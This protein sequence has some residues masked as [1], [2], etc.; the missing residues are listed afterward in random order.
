MKYKIWFQPIPG[1]SIVQD[2]TSVFYLNLT[3]DQRSG[4]LKAFH[5]LTFDDPMSGS[6]LAILTVPISG[7]EPEIDLYTLTNTPFLIQ[8][9]FRIAELQPFL[10]YN[11]P[12]SYHHPPYNFYLLLKANQESL[13][14]DLIIISGIEEFQ[15][16]LIAL[17]MLKLDPK[18]TI[19]SLQN[20]NGFELLK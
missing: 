12:Q 1:K 15:G 11:V 5:I 17:D 10:L 19:L 8:G 2:G 3:N 6:R 7:P 18:S 13:Y 9:T 16:V 14:Y 20:I 4:L